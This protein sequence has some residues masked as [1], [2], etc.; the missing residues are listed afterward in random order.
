[1]GDETRRDA[2]TQAREGVKETLN[3]VVA[4]LLSEREWLKYMFAWLSLLS[5]CI[6][7]NKGRSK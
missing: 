3:S 7:E 1:M 4:A 6:G 5:A 2:M